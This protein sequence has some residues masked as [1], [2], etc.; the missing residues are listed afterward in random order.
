MPRV[1][2]IK[3]IGVKAFGIYGII[4]TYVPRAKTFFV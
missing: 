1:K 4:F 2:F 3:V